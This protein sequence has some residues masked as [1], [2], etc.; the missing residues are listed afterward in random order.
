MK[1]LIGFLGLVV[2]GCAGQYLTSSRSF[3]E[4]KQFYD[5]TMV[6]GVPKIQVTRASFEEEVANG[7][8]EQGVD[9]MSSLRIGVLIPMEGPVSER[10]AT[11]INEQLLDKGTKASLQWV[12]MFELT[13]PGNIDKVPSKYALELTEALLKESNACPME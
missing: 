12:G 11:G 13:N 8:K 1:F 4:Q 2:S 6:I 3:G 9:A 7:L 10:D 5:K